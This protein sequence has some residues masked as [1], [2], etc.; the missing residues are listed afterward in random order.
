MEN[1]IFYSP[2]F[3]IY[4]LMH[5]QMKRD[6]GLDN[7][8]NLWQYIQQY[9]VANSTSLR[10][11]AIH[12]LISGFIQLTSGFM[13]LAAAERRRNILRFHCLFE[14]KMLLVH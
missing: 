7:I 6:V 3:L 12:W 10:N 2:A 1:P 14:G 13:Q 11:V 5:L 8:I 9:T 4:I